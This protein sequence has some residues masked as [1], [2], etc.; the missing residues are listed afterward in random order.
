MTDIEVNEVVPPVEPQT[1][2]KIEKDL[3]TMVNEAEKVYRTKKHQLA[4]EKSILALEVDWNKVN[5]VRVRQGLPKITNE[6]NRNHYFKVHFAKEDEELL[7]LEL[8]YRSLE[9]ELEK[10]LLL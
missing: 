5:D 10:E 7:Q 3:V 6:A 9:R 4:L 8:N 1:E 2:E